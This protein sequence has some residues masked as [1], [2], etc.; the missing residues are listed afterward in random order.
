MRLRI[1]FS[2]GDRI[3][4]PTPGCKGVLEICQS[5]ALKTQGSSCSNAA[6]AGGSLS[7]CVRCR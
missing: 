7:L 4:C 1:S 5:S 6:T 3:A 2:E